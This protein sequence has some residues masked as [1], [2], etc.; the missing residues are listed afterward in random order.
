M[1]HQTALCFTGPSTH[2]LL[3]GAGLKTTVVQQAV[4]RFN[5]YDIRDIKV[6]ENSSTAQHRFRPFWGSSVHYGYTCIAI[7]RISH[8][9]KHEAAWCGT[10]SCL[11]TPQT[12]DSTVF[13]VVENASTAHDWFCPSWGSSGRRSPR[14]SVNLM[15]YL[16]PNWTDFD[17]YTNLQIN[18]V[19][20]EIHPEPS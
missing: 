10:F 19:L 14:V 11:E 16:N 18:L 7:S 2:C 13:Q 1:L 15:F 20:R 4:S 3:T 12:R 5:C 9:L 8:Q 6:A 17:K